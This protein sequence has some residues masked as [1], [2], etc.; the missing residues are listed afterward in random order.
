MCRKY[1]KDGVFDSLLSEQVVPIDSYFTFYDTHNLLHSFEL[2]PGFDFEIILPLVRDTYRIS[3][4]DVTPKTITYQCKKGDRYTGPHVFCMND[5][6]AGRMLVTRNNVKDTF[7]LAVQDPG[8]VH[9]MHIN[10]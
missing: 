9:L 7:T 1:V 2:T 6:Y 4:I 3:H 8:N 10:D 5:F